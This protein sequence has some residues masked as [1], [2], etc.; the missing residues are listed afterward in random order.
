M[1][2][3]EFEAACILDAHR[4][5]MRVACAR[6]RASSARFRAEQIEAM[7]ENIKAIDYSL[8]RVAGSS[9]CNDRAE[10]LMHRMERVAAECCE[11]ASEWIRE[12]DRAKL[13]LDR[14]S[15]QEHAAILEMHYLAGASW[16]NTATAFGYSGPGIY[17]VRKQALKGF[18]EVM[19]KGIS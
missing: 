5:L 6:S 13:V 4:A 19:L 7:K 16:A 12:A 3:K 11:A 1:L 15:N 8:E 10:D 18:F 17:D 14:M 9:G 2:S